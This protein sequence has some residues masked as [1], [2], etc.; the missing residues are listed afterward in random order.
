MSLYNLLPFLN[1]YKTLLA[2][3]GTIVLALGGLLTGDMD[4]PM[5]I[6]TILGGLA[7]LGIGHKVEKNG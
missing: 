6:Q 4:V 2:G 3:Y 5:A 7:I 1:G